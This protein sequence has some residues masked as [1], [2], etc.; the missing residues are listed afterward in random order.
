[1]SSSFF[2][3]AA[4]SV[5]IFFFLSSSLV[6]FFFASSASL[7]YSSA[8]FFAASTSLLSSSS[9]ASFL[10][11]SASSSS[12]FAAASSSAFLRAS[13]TSAALTAESL[14][15]SGLSPCLG[16]GGRVFLSFG[17]FF[18]SIDNSASASACRL[19][20]SVRSF[21]SDLFADETLN[22]AEAGACFMG[23]DMILSALDSL[24]VIF[25]VTSV[26][27]CIVDGSP[28]LELISSGMKRA[29]GTPFF[30]RAGEERD[31]LGPGDGDSNVSR[32]F[33]ASWAA[34][35]SAS[36]RSF[37]FFS[38]SALSLR[39]ACSVGTSAVDFFF[40]F[41]SASF[42]FFAAASSSAFFFASASA[43]ACSSSDFFLAAASSASLDFSFR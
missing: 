37:S 28:N 23:E 20:A 30:L 33:S 22:E 42:F 16:L 11:L 36:M 12:S 10:F 5:S 31:E 39:E 35:F 25:V 41:P 3:F 13:S 1:S 9:A 40:F 38:A 34:L 26:S 7:L 4:A 17:S 8:F 24:A 2:F 29:L 43:C 19:N 14:L 32:C 15:F 18:V 21:E 27:E 6:F